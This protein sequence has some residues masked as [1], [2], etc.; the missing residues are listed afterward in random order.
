MNANLK[1]LDQKLN[2]LHL[3][4]TED[5]DFHNFSGS[6]SYFILG[7]L[8]CILELPDI[9]SKYIVNTDEIDEATTS[10]ILLGCHKIR[11]TYPNV[12][13]PKLSRILIHSPKSDNFFKLLIS[14]ADCCLIKSGN[15]LNR[16]DRCGTEDS[17]TCSL[18][19]IS[20][21][22]T[23]SSFATKDK[24]SLTNPYMRQL[25]KGN[26]EESELKAILERAATLRKNVMVEC[27]RIRCARNCNKHF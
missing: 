5:I 21:E 2:R 19:S 11:S 3:A 26:A 8:F 15:K 20:T 16:V 25:K 13:L 1:V 17:V 4:W 6:L 18:N 22:S 9:F 12:A 24:S 27:Q 14:L 10:L 23:N 7:K